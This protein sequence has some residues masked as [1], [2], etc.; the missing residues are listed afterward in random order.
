VAATSWRRNTNASARSSTRFSNGS[1]RASCSA[2]LRRRKTLLHRKTRQAAASRPS[3]PR[4][5]RS[6]RCARSRPA[7][8]ALDSYFARNEPSN[9]AL[10]LVRQAQQ[11][12][13]KSFLDAMR[14]LA[15]SFVDQAA[16]Q[17][18][19]SDSFSLPLDRLSEFAMVDESALYEGPEPE[20]MTV[21][22]R[23][24]AI[25]LMAAVIGFYARVE[26]SSPVPFLLERARALAGRDFLAILKDILPAD[27]L[28]NPHG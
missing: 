12:V 28:R 8:A 9:P 3:T 23:P 1:T 15:P 17:I 19:R 11:L 2:I 5:A 16:V 27:T 18:G 26:P 7:L 24:E 13:G 21:S 4:P 20:P 22:S 10:L 6:A 25:G 14:V